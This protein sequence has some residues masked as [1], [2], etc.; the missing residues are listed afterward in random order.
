[1]QPI[2]SVTRLVVP[3]GVLLGATVGAALVSLGG[4]S[5]SQPTRSA[6]DTPESTIAVTHLPPLLTASAEERRTLAFDA[7]CLPAAGGDAEAPC[8]AAGSVFARVGDRGAFRAVPLRRDPSQSGARL[9]ATVPDDLVRSPHALSYYAVIEDRA[10]S[11]TTTLPTGGPEAP[12]RSL[13][14]GHA[15]EI[16]LGRHAFGAPRLASERV[17]AAPWGSG[18]GEVGLEQGRNLPPIGGSSFDVREDGMVY[19]LDEANRRALRWRSGSAEPS[20]I[21]L[22]IDGT[23]AD[24]A[25][26]DDT[27]YVLETAGPPG[28]P[29][30]LRAF[31]ASG[32]AMA[33]TPLGE[34]AY[35]VRIGPDGAPVV[36]EQASGQWVRAASPSGRPV[37][38]ATQRS[39]GRAGQPAVDGSEVVVLRHDDEIRVA[40]IDRRG[41]RRAWRITSSTP[42]A[43]VQL[44]E[45]A[46]NRLV[47][48]A[49]VYTDAQDEFVVLVLGPQGITQRFAVRSADWA[50]TAPLSRFRLVGSALYQLG[51]TPAGVFVDRFDLEV[52]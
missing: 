14:L 38:I 32:R 50:E 40:V 4:A 3:L 41:S 49:R 28:R 12:Y 24:L 22:A 36:R 51:S 39:S 45:P 29:G 20:A 26:S 2:V 15:V 5:A 42:I 23:I 13:P 34:R 43:E 7:Y 37:S 18:P 8:D 30:L 1:M 35:R 47:V 44:A 33:S 27:L 52:E 6:A 21:P 19:V 17:V 25:V 10:T 11:A 9:V 48:V 46:G 16:D 31:A